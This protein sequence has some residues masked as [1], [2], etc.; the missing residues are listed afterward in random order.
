MAYVE[1]SFRQLQAQG[2]VKTQGDFAQMLGVSA[3]TISAAKKGDVRYLTPSLISK[4]EYLLEHQD[5]DPNTTKMIPVLPI[6]AMAGTLVEFFQAVKDYD[7]EKVAS[8]V[9]GAEYAI[10]IYGDSMSPE[11]PSGSLCLI[12]RIDEKQ[13]IAWNEVYVLDTDN[14]AVIKKIRR[15]EKDGVVECV[16]INPAYQPFTI[17][18]SY[19]HGWYKVLMV[20]SVK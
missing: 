13:F 5:N 11:Y 18:T 9:K 20:M 12:K 14:G 4:I 7:C 16:S 19:I 3:N 1:S 17:D 10:K 15:T 2:K 8:P 6:E